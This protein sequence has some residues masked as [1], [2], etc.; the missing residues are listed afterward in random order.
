[1]FR[2]YLDTPLAT[3][4]H[5]ITLK[6]GTA[7]VIVGNCTKLCT[8]NHK[9]GA[10]VAIEAVFGT[11]MRQGSLVDVTVQPGVPVGLWR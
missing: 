3:T 8:V 4:L 2:R 5:R 9:L 1:M 7:A 11:H 10:K 6:L